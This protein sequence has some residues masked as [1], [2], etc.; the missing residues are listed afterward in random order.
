MPAMSD[1]KRS[2]LVV[3]VSNNYWKGLVAYE[4]TYFY[5]ILH[6]FTVTLF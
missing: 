5:G 2:S 4:K 6:R 1:V 3:W